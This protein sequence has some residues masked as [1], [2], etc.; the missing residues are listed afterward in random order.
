MVVNNFANTSH[1]KEVHERTKELE[2]HVFGAPQPHKSWRE[3]T[4][5]AIAVSA[6]LF[7]CLRLVKRYAVPRWI[8]WLNARIAKNPERLPTISKY[9]SGKKTG[10]ESNQELKE[11]IE[12]LVA[13][14]KQ[15]LEIIM[16]RVNSGNSPGRVPALD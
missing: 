4:L 2:K 8:N 10:D 1:V 16:Q 11:A 12:R 3:F 13:E 5:L 14:H 15:Q 9:V 6:L 7:G